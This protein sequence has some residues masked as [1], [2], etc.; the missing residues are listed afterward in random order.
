L[1]YRGRKCG[2]PENELFNAL[3]LSSERG[4]YFVFTYF[5]VNRSQTNFQMWKDMADKEKALAQKA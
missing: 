1:F 2:V 5:F 3:N 4:H